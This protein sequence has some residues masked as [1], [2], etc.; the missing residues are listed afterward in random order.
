M[1]K[2]WRIVAAILTA[3]VLCVGCGGKR[4]SETAS[5]MASLTAEDIAG[6]E[7]FRWP[8]VT[9]EQLVAALN[10]AAA[11]EITAEEAAQAEAA[12][13]AEDEDFERYI[14]IP[15]KNGKYLM[16]ACGAAAD[17]V[18]V[19]D[20][21]AALSSTYPAEKSTTAYF[22]DHDLYQLLWDSWEEQRDEPVPELIPPERLEPLPDKAELTTEVFTCQDLTVEVSGV[23]YTKKG[24]VQED[25]DQTFANDIFV[26]CPGATFT[27]TAAG[28]ENDSDGVPHANWKYYDPINGTMELMPGSG[29][30]EITLNSSIGRESFGVLAFAQYDGWLQI[31]ADD[32]AEVVRRAIE[33]DAQKPATLSTRVLSAALDEAETARVAAMYTGSEL[34]QSRGW[35]DEQLADHFAAVKAVYEAQYDGTKT[36]LKSGTITEYFYLMQYDNGTWRITDSGMRQAG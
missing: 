24:A 6:F 25:E 21:G 7:S 17:I 33:A 23:Y 16:A 35:T 32:P 28:V 12:N 8:N 36:A 15:I 2:Y 18:C 10:R 11:H 26:V 29:P 20:A 27:V 3:V 30:Y 14:G 19:F 22:R 13:T 31:P 9:A 34:A 1:R 4:L 5:A